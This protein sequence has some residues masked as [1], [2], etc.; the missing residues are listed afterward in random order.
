MLWKEGLKAIEMGG[1]IVCFPK[2][3]CPFAIP[4]GEAV[5][6]ISIWPLNLYSGVEQLWVAGM[7]RGRKYQS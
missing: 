2:W 4:A 6:I 5:W 7:W 1:I 3:S